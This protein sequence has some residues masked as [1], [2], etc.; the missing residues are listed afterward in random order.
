MESIQAIKQRFEIIGNDVKLNRALEKAMQVAPT[1]ISV[2]VT[3]ESGVGK[4]SIPKIIHSLSHRK[5]A[6]YIAVNC[7]AIPEG[8]IDSELFGHEKGAFTGATQTRSGYFEVADGGTIFLD[9]VGEL[10][11]TTQVRLLR[12]LENG[13]FLKVG[14]SQVQKTNVRIVAATNINMAEAISK[15]KFREDLYYR[16]S[17]V[18]INIPPLRQRQGDIH[19]LFRKFASDFAQKYKMPTIRLEDDAVQ[20]LLKYRW[21]GNI[22][23]LRNVAEQISV[24]EESREI[25]LSC[26]NSYLPNAGDSHLPAVI[27]TKSKESD[28]S[29]EREIL[30]KVL[31]DMKGDLNDL[32]KL[33]LELL[34]EN[35]TDKVQEENRNLIRKIYG[36]TEEAIEEESTALEVLPSAPLRRERP[37]EPGPEDKYHFA[38]EIEEEETLSLQEKEIELIKKSLER[39]RG[40]RKAAASELGISERTL[41]RKIK[42]YDL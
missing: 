26:L 36:D 34:K 35:D 14:S 15:G 38:E 16:L 2:L 18:E 32:K 10:P 40:K 5:H 20:L 4:E 23:Q 17:T 11:L 22:R 9:E 42:Q 27:G 25:S 6:K 41:Y 28:F 7:G 1:D 12:V 21:P 31:F 37:A 29:N 24:L 33:T 3:G 8:T 30:Y 19:L 39:N 13:E